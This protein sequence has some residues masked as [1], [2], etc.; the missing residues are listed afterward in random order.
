MSEPSIEAIVADR[1]LSVS[2]KS[3]R[4]TN[5]L[6][7]TPDHGVSS[8]V[9]A[10]CNTRDSRL[11]AFL[12]DYLALLPG[13]RAEKNH[14]AECLR[15]VS[16]LAG[17][18]SRMVPWLTPELLD[19]FVADYLAKPDKRSPLYS[20]MFEIATFFPA[21]LRPRRDA[22]DSPSLHRGL[23]SG[24]PDT[25]IDDFLSRWRRDREIDA[26]DSIARFRTPRAADTI[27]G[28][29]AE[30]P[31][32]EQWECWLEM[33]GRLPN[34]SSANFTPSFLGFVV[35]QGE[36]PHVMGGT[37]AGQV[38]L[39][40]VCQKPAERVL[41][42]AKDAAPFTLHSNPS[43]F[44]YSCDCNQLDFTT[45]QER[46]DDRR[47]FFGPAGSGGPGGHV[48]PTKCS[49]ELETHPNQVGVSI[50]VSY[51]F[52]RHQVGGS[53]VWIHARALPHCPVC[54]GI[55]R[56]LASVDSGMTPF[57]RLGFTGMLFGFW[58]DACAVATTIRQA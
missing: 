28:L 10:L 41:T 24:A 46:G 27:A 48:V 3:E 1:S 5:T 54:Q 15:R 25:W 52:A 55:M 57:G 42:L 53:P 17:G 36:T 34:G 56:F 58:C 37:V 39:C 47:V 33:A 8:A 16:D 50:D 7:S 51:G 11:A 29:R 4:L 14:A 30:V 40:P 26:I 18:A 6:Y 45:V 22:F 13:R 35:Q 9:E 44:W 19:R 12:G 2:Q 49:L 32:R 21:L 43:F 38:P 20:V 23:L 31:D